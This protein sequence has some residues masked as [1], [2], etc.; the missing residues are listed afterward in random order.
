MN[1][2]PGVITAADLSRLL[3]ALLLPL[4]L[5]SCTKPAALPPPTRAVVAYEVKSSAV[6]GGASYA[7][8]IRP[9]VESALAFRI[10]GKLVERRVDVG[11]S[12]KVGQVLARLD[13]S[14]PDLAAQA[15]RS[16]QAAAQADAE[17][18]R[19]EAARFRSLR[20]QNFVSQSALD[21]KL[22]VLKAAESRLAAAQ[23]QADVAGHQTQYSELVAD[24]AGTVAGVLAEVGQVV[25]AGQPVLRVARPSE[26]EVAI[27]VAENRV[28]ELNAARHIGVTLWADAER[29]YRGRLRE[30]SPQA[31]PVTRTYAARI[32][33]VDADDNVR[34]GMTATVTL[35]TTAP[36]ALLVPASSMVQLDG[37]PAVWVL[38]DGG[39]IAKRPVVIAA[40]RED[41]ALVRSGLRA[42][43]KIVAAGGQKLMP[44]EKVRVLESRLQAS[45][46]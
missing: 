20:A 35:A 15:A 45:A 7:G 26:K 19:A 30:I 27:A 24:A 42:G 31:D 32:A 13:P 3:P 40:W 11:A 34:L 18:A 22:A 46:P 41:G 6:G 21:A 4:V 25:A 9:R 36:N 39:V 38:G 1:E 23:A 44:G 5:A 12:V 14:D 33:L 8:E 37:R 10:G 29:K 17:L 43:E 16:Q 2:N 28:G